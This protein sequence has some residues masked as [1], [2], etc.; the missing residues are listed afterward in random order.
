ME[1]V[2]CIEVLSW[3]LP[4]GTKGNHDKFFFRVTG[5]WVAIREWEYPVQNGSA[6][7]LALT[8]STRCSESVC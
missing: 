4:D 6:N 5:L 7:H 2:V 3:L 1:V 8:I